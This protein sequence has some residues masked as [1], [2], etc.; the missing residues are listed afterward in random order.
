MTPAGPTTATEI[1]MRTLL[2]HETTHQLMFEGRKWNA[3]T[4]K[5][6][7]IDHGDI[8]CEGIATMLENYFWDGQK[9]VW[10][11]LREIKGA[12]TGQ[13]TTS[14]FARALEARGELPPMD[15]LSML[16]NAQYVGD[17]GLRNYAQGCCLAYYM[18]HKCAATVR[19]KYL[20]AAALVHSLQYGRETFIEVMKGE[21]TKKLDAEFKAWLETIKFED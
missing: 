8:V 19:E 14:R 7:Q 10:R 21:D 9:F 1:G 3:S 13:V 15:E 18:L 6:G 17:N 5:R 4:A 20:K 16:T 2:Q 11:F 12:V